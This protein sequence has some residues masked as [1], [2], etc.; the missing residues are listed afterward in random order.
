MCGPCAPDFFATRLL[1]A[2]EFGALV[3][4]LG[5]GYVLVNGIPRPRSDLL[6]A[7]WPSF[8]VNSPARML[9][10]FPKFNR[11]LTALSL[12]AG[13]HGLLSLGFRRSSGDVSAAALAKT[14]GRQHINVGP[15]RQNS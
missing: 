6:Q 3:N 13:D 11:R 4:D 2:L 5:L 14:V 15:C 9:L 10:P 12:L 7:V 8:H 1:L